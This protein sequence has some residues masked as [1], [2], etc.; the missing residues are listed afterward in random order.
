[1]TQL[2]FA[3]LLV[4]LTL[5]ISAPVFCGQTGVLDVD[6][7]SASSLCAPGFG[8]ATSSLELYCKYTCP[9][10]SKGYVVSLEGFTYIP[11]AAS[12]VCHGQNIQSTG[13]SPC[14]CGAL[15]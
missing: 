13:N 9:S 10:D 2:L 6:S 5:T 3:S 11:Q 4:L 14:S 7:Q 12:F 8:M 1:M 15:V